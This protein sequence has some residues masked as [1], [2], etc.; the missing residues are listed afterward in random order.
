MASGIGVP[1][2]SSTD[3]RIQIAP[4]VPSGTTYG[5]SGHGSPIAKNGPIV[6]EGVRGERHASSSSRSSGVARPL[7]R[8]MSHRNANAHSGTVSEWS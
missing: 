1:S 4:G 8:T 2:P 5:P 7:P 6:W 3:P